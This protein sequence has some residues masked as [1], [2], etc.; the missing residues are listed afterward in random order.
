MDSIM[1]EQ[2]VYLEQLKKV[3]EVLEKTNAVRLEDTVH[4]TDQGPLSLTRFPEEP[5][6]L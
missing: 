3:T 5:V 6:A 4:I 2:T 1:V